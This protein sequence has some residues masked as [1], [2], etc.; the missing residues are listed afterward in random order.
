MT[1]PPLASDLL[2]I[3]VRGDFKPVTI[4]PNQLYKDKL[5]GEVE[6]ADS[7]IEVRI[8]GEASIFNAGWLRCQATVNSL[9]LQTEQE[10]EQERLR[11][12]AVGLLK[13]SPAKPIAALGIN[14]QVHFPVQSLDTWHAVGDSL[15]HNEVWTGILN[16]PGMR[17][18]IF[19][20]ERADQYTGRMQ[21]QVE[22]SFAHS[23]HIRRL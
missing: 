19:W 9:E 21:I 23:R 8:P 4:S 14:R 12:L 17:S 3:V 15:V 1:L 10:A 16:A 18:V 6:C 13:S 20:G 7:T 5:I 2:S 11:D 22:P